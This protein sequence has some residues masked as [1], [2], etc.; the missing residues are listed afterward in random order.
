MQSYHWIWLKAHPERSEAWL[1]E[2][3]RDGFDIHHLDGD[4]FNDDPL[5][6]VLIE[7]GDHLMLHN[8]KARFSRVAGKNLRPGRP[9]KPEH[10]HACLLV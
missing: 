5:N 9:R 3:L 1:E 2:R 8:G 6:L 7:C 4:H 10:A